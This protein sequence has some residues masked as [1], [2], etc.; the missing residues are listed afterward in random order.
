MKTLNTIQKL[1][2]AAGVSCLM[3]SGAF[4]QTTWIGPVGGSWN[5]DANWSSNTQP[6]STGGMII[7][8]GA[9][10]NVLSN[11]S[12]NGNN[13]YLQ[14]DLTNPPT[15]NVTG[16]VGGYQ[17]YCGGDALSSGSSALGGIMNVTG[18]LIERGNGSANF[19]INVGDSGASC[20][21]T[22]NFGNTTSLGA[23][24]YI[25]QASGSL[26]A[27][28]HA[29]TGAT[30]SGVINLTGYGTF[31]VATADDAGHNAIIYL[32]SY[33]GIGTLN[34]VGGNETIN[35]GGLDIGQIGNTGT[36]VFNPTIDSTGI[37][38]IYCHNTTANHGL[39]ICSTSQFHLTL[40]SGFAATVGQVFKLVDS[41]CPIY[42]SF[43][44]L[45]EGA[46]LSNV[47]GSGYSFTVTYTGVSSYSG[48]DA[49]AL[50]TTAVPE[51]QTFALMFAGLG[52]LMG[53]RR[54]RRK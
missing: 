27:Q 54:M 42:G 14:A 6:Y 4:A 25:G 40:G 33:K 51:P 26:A 7:T 18:G 5:V 44:G 50:T 17:I 46:T 22:F 12:T 37:S 47:G 8:P 38:T 45:A 30:D 49:F 29:G 35:T 53:G 28:V 9:V 36:G 11:K 13:I 48:G 19:N 43:T 15:L 23:P 52:M 16:T 10:V 41:A 20:T 32:G 39:Q 24:T 2:L 3:G 1:F 21:G 34:V 31:N